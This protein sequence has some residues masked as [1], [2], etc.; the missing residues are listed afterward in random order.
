MGEQADVAPPP[1]DRTP[2]FAGLFVLLLCSPFLLFNGY[3]FAGWTTQ[4]L[5][6]VSQGPLRLAASVRSTSPDGKTR[7]EA[8]RDGTARLV[9][10]ATGKVLYTRRIPVNDYR[11]VAVVWHGNQQ[12]K[13]LC[14][15]RYPAMALA[16][17]YTWNSAS[18]IITED[19]SS[20]TVPN[21]E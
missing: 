10:L 16:R 12:V 2:F 7:F 14:H 3:L 1:K 21:F 17:E 13:V 9:R 6:D 11:C 15:I 4:A 19:L 18:G 8:D 20:Q 5:I